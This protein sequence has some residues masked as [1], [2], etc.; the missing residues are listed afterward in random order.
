[1]FSVPEALD[2]IHEQGGIAAAAHPFSPY[3]HSLETRIH[4]LKLDG[5]EVFNAYHRDAYSNLMA[6]TFSPG[7]LA[8]LGSSMHIHLI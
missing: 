1:M 7:K 8:R 3:C 4:D 6:Q 5:V 2:L